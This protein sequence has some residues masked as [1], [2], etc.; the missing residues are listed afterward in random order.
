MLQKQLGR[1]I[2]ELRHARNLTQ[3]QLA[4]KTGYSV[5]F[6]S[7]VERGVNGPSIAGLE[8]IARVLNVEIAGLFTFER[9]QMPRK[10]RQIKRHNR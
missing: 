1:R 7:L 8:K 5:D 10:S 4:R 3:V 2:A 9:K 6:I